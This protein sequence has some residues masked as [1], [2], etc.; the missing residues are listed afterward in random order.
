MN[1]RIRRRILL[2]ASA[3]ATTA[4]TGALPLAALAQAPH[5]PKVAL[6]MKSL[7]NEFFLTMETGAKD[8][9][10]HNADQFDLVTNGIKNETDTAAQIQIVEQM[11]VSKVDAIVLAPADSKALVPVVKKAVDAGIIVVNID[12]KLD[13]DVLKSKDLN[14]PFVGPDNR[15]GARLVGDYLGKRLKSGD[16]V[17]ILEG[18]STTTN[19]QQRTAGFKDAMEAV[20]A[21]IVSTQSGEWEIDKGNAV[22]SA[23]LN[24]YPD[25]K[26]LLCGNDNMAIGAVS[27]V[28]AAGK[29][30]KVYV[31][32]YDNIDA[33]K[34]MLKDGRVLATADQ[35]A[36]KQAVFGIDTALKALKEHKKQSELSGIVETPVV[37]VTK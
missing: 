32:G 35:Y 37:L 20:G 13:A 15:K 1:S 21:K 10:K 27:A 19:A 16:Q 31:V 18:V 25:I 30:G 22:A 3:L 17:G 4:V 9:Q 29:Q 34:P 33:I 5:K 23:M 26:A 8:Y 6:V 12:N 36:A 11:I 14:V 2:A 24:E 28:R 7:A